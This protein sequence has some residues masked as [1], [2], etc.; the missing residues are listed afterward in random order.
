[1]SS[2]TD[3][4][5]VAHVGKGIQPD[6]PHTAVFERCL[7]RKTATMAYRYAGGRYNL[8]WPDP[9]RAPYAEI[10]AV[11]TWTTFNVS[12]G[13]SDGTATFGVPW[14]HCNQYESIKAMIVLGCDHGGQ[15]LET[16]IK[17]D[18]LVDVVATTNGLATVMSY[19]SVGGIMQQD[20]RWR[21][22]VEGVTGQLRLLIGYPQVDSPTLPGNRRVQVIPEVQVNTTASTLFDVGG[23][24]R[25]WLK[26]LSL[27]DVPETNEVGL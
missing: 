6:G 1:M 5:I 13:T 24:T 14:F 27:I 20:V 19:T 23:T 21:E 11:T 26:Q 17:T 7:A 15:K 4:R 8:I 9:S 3:R 22:S 10:T 12:D 18:D 25:V 16:R 2:R